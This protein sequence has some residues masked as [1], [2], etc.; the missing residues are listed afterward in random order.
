MSA[1]ELGMK[2]KAMYSLEHINKVAMIHLFGVI[3]GKTMRSENIKPIEVLKAAKMPESYVTE[4]NK[5][6][7][8]SQYVTLRKEY[9]D[10]YED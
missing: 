3:Y 2:L 1:Y 6:I 7:N 8:L 10:V 9:K 4:I 5:G